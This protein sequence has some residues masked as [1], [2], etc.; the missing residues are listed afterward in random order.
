MAERSARPGAGEV[1]AAACAARGQRRSGR[2]LRR[3]FLFVFFCR[4]IT[5]LS[6]WGRR[7]SQNHYFGSPPKRPIYIFGFHAQRG[8]NRPK[9]GKN[10]PKMQK[11]A[12]KS[13]M[14]AAVDAASAAPI[15][16][17]CTDCCARL[18]ASAPA[19]LSTAAAWAAAAAAAAHCGRAGGAERAPGRCRAARRG[20][21]GLSPPP[22][23]EPPEPNR[24]GDGA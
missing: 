24:V 7:G 1:G 5:L 9:T 23:L 16:A 20:N 22:L 10:V 2:R 3:P 11:N 17:V 12:V 18:S 6:F 21:N 13:I 8:P 14:K 4:R 19:V 15:A